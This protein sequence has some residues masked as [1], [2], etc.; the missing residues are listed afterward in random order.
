MTHSQDIDSAY[1]TIFHCNSS[2]E[3]SLRNLETLNNN[4]EE[5]K[6]NRF[7]WH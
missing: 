5:K 2:F 7:K 6:G 4:K 3:Q 1:F